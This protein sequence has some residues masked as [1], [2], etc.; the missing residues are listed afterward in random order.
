ETRSDCVPAD[1]Q[2]QEN[3]EADKLNQLVDR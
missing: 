2:R 1:A 3:F